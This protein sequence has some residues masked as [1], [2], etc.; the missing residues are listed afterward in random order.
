V[1]VATWTQD[2]VDRLKAA[3]GSGVLTV[4]YDGPPKRSIT[5]HSLRDMR[6]LLAEMV[7]EVAGETGAAPPSFRRV[8]WR[9]GFDAE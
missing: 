6:E 7:R 5:Y 1:A 2:D 4:S 3:V 9:R 8:A